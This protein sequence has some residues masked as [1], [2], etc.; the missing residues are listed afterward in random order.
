MK[1]FL[2]FFLQENLQSLPSNP[3]I[4]T[5]RFIKAKL[6]RQSTLFYFTIQIQTNMLNDFQQQKFDYLFGVFDKNS[7]GQLEETDLQT[8]F[9]GMPNQGKAIKAARR[10]WLLLKYYGDREKDGKLTKDEWNAW[11][12]ALVKDLKTT[13]VGSSR[14]RRWA[15]AIFDSIDSQERGGISIEEYQTWFDSF[16]LAGNAVPIF[17]SLDKD[18]EGVVSLESFREHTREFVRV[19]EAAIGNHLFGTLV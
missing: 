14:F 8:A 2:F 13:E 18:E 3:S 12:V 10:W 16:G 17:E 7:N 5:L 6:R 19:D 1:P 15:D 4:E 11:A 9:E